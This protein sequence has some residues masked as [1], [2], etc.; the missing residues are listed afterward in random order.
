M[1]REPER[2]YDSFVVRLWRDPAS[3]RLLRAEVE[4]VQTGNISAERGVPPEWILDC[5]RSCLEGRVGDGA[6]ERER[7]AAPSGSPDSA[8]GSGRPVGS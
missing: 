4:H 3:G 2:A 6:G 8:R 5:V 1:M 7:E